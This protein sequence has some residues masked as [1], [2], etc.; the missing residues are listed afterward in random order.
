MSQ[1]GA[2]LALQAEVD[3]ACIRAQAWSKD[4]QLHSRWSHLGFGRAHEY[5]YGQKHI[6]GQC[7][8]HIARND[9]KSTRKA[10]EEAQSKFR[11]P[12]VAFAEAYKAVGEKSKPDGRY[13]VNACENIAITEQFIR[14]YLSASESDG[15]RKEL[16][17]YEAEFLTKLHGCLTDAL[18]ELNEFDPVLCHEQIYAKS[19]I[20][21][22]DAVLRLFKDTS[23]AACLPVSQQKL[24]LQL[25]MDRNF[26]PSM[27]DINEFGVKA[28]C[29][30]EYVLQE[31]DDTL[32]EDLSG[33]A[34]PVSADVI[35]RLLKDALQGHVQ[36]KRFIPAFAIESQFQRGDI[37]PLQQPFQKARAELSQDLQGAR[38]RVTHAM[39]LSALDQKDASQLLR[40]IEDIHAQNSL[41]KGIGHPE[42]ASPAYPDFPHATATLQHQVINVLDGKL[43]EAKDKLNAELVAFEEKHGDESR[44][45][46]Q[47]I[48][49]M[50]STNNPASIRTAHDALTILRNSGKLPAYISDTGRN[51]AKEFEAFLA[52]MHK[53]RSQ[54]LLL[55]SLESVLTNPL[56]ADVPACI[57]ELTEQQR[58]EAAR[59]VANWKDV[60][61]TRGIDA[62]EKAG[63]FF[64][65]LGI[66]RPVS[67]PDCTSRNTPAKFEFPP[68]AFGSISSSDCFLPPSL[69]SNASMIVGH[70]VSGNH[71]ESEV[72]TLIQDIS[73]VPTFILSRAGFNL[74]RRAKLSG[75]QPVLLIDD[76]LIAY[77]AL[78]PDNRV[79]RMMEIA[80]LTFHTIPY[81]AEGTYVPREMFFGRQRE[82]ISLRGVKS[83]A[84]LYGGRRLGKSSL[85]AQIEREESMVAGS[86]AIYIPMDRDFAGED[87]VLFAWRKL[88]SGLV[89]RNLIDVMPTNDEMAWEK[90][91]EWVEQQ[92]S[93]STQ[94][95]SKCYLLFD[96][97]DNLMAHEL[98]LP[99]KQTG[100]IRS[101]QRTSENIGP[102][103]QLR[104]VI[105][106]LHNLARMT[107]ESNSALGKAET[108][109]LE[110][111]STDDDILR[112]VELVTK[113]MAALG[114]YFPLGSEDLPLRILSIC[115]F[116]PA[117]IQ[118]YCRKLL[119][120]MY[121]KRTTQN[122][123][124]N[125]LVSDL[126][127]VERDHDLLSELQQKFGWTLDLD[128]R[129]K[130]IGLILADSYYSEAEQGKNE[131]LTVG[132]IRT[133]C[134]VMVPTHFKGMNAGAYE[135]LVDEMRKLNVLEKNG[136]RYRLRNPSIAML[137]GD[138]A[139]INFQLQA[140][141][142]STPEESPQPRRSP[143]RTHCN[144]WQQLKR[145]R[146]DIPNAGCVD[147][148]Q[149]GGH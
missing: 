83:L 105:A 64:A 3:R 33:V 96:E 104:Y 50:L 19:A 7:I 120:H 11:K 60:C 56:K 76:N 58:S 78:H 59:F 21:V 112:G 63:D 66:G 110:P 16:P 62:A 2:K 109:A 128:K 92:L 103:F 113:P 131:G 45:D 22:F 23:G 54:E 143:Q 47:R 35:V 146:A 98:D 91:Q 38:Q 135:G 71:P 126:E 52:E 17:P 115:N 134:E 142:E 94:K 99:S 24:L 43:G 46:V 75:H 132:E 93:S 85:L 72:S 133:W 148:C 40:I 102:K 87:H 119:E 79:R 74:Q 41:E 73:S 67:M 95:C 55:N 77:M 107:Q 25:A 48:R 86:A 53:I 88:Y 130:A 37:K 20:T 121:N 145:Y 8:G 42:G 140:L 4:P 122:A 111:F 129:Y 9:V 89:Q 69:G 30:P 10:F 116:Y 125:I 39:A 27:R 139:R 108:I 82:I 117:F 118:I 127:S 49:Q 70:V 141:A 106:G 65:A 32:A 80:T 14:D 6:I 15:D 68:R 81:S 18:S 29:S 90:I 51:A 5:V 123:W 36:S 149:H 84:I 100:F 26:D 31:I 12:A 57:S 97:A 13:G 28:I 137:I 124:A 61:A 147:T 101:L 34:S 138:R 136:S 114:F 1:I 144:Q 44:K